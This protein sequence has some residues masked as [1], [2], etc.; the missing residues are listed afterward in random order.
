MEE[1]SHRPAG[2]PQIGFGVTA[3]KARVYHGETF[4]GWIDGKALGSDARTAFG[5]Q[6]MLR[7][8]G[9]HPIGWPKQRRKRFGTGRMIKL[10]HRPLVFHRALAQAD[11]MLANA[12]RHVGLVGRDHR[13]APGK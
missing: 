10:L 12:E 13:R 1:S 9:S 2:M 11:G 3:E 4:G 5:A 6:P 8:R 7:I